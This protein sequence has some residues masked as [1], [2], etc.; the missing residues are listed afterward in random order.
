MNARVLAIAFGALCALT[1]AAVYAFSGAANTSAPQGPRPIAG[2]TGEVVSGV[3]DA[4][5]ARAARAFFRSLLERT[6]RGRPVPIAS[7]TRQFADRLEAGPVS[8]S[9]TASPRL[10]AMRYTPLAGGV[11]DV[12]VRVDED[13][14]DGSTQPL[15]AY[16]REIDGTWLAVGARTLDGDTESRQAAAPRTPPAP[17]TRVV[18]AYALAARS[19]TPDTLRARYAEQLRLSAGALRRDLQR[20]PP[21]RQQIGAYRADGARADA[22]IDDVQVVRLTATQITFSVVLTERA[23]SAG[24]TTSQ[25]TVNTAELQLHDGAWRV[26]NFTASP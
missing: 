7:A 19:W 13:L 6:D 20:H 5:L 8:G 10:G 17:A 21:T 3:P 14:P 22:D 1:V 18:S 15:S 25:R 24:A 23:T 12:T 11:R 9:P 2:I 26:W 4:R 16:F